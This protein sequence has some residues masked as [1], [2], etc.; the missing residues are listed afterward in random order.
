MMFT[1]WSEILISKEKL[2]FQGLFTLKESRRK[3]ENLKH[4]GYGVSTIT[5]FY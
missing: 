3:S 5:N 1:T 4:N 2:L